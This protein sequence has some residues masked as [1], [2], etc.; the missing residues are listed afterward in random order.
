MQVYGKPL[1]S[2]H[3]MRAN[4]EDRLVFN[5]AEGRI[6]YQNPVIRETGVRAVPMISG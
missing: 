2:L 4:V 3:E 1:I 6:D 5:A